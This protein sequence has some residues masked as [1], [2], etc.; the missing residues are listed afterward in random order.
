MR[1]ILD[2]LKHGDVL[3]EPC[4]DRYKEH[5]YS[6]SNV[7]ELS[8]NSSKVSSIAFTVAMLFRS[9]IVNPSN[10]LPIMNLFLKKSITGSRHIKDDYVWE[11]RDSSILV[12][13]GHTYSR[14]RIYIRSNGIWI[15]MPE[16][17]F[18]SLYSFE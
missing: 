8:P 11:M 15:R 1:P 18:L 12:T 7:L 9:E 14:Y 16:P 5:L 13:Q 6:H 17:L 4:F 2:A 10:S 3:I